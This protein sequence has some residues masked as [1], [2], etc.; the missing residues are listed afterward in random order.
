MLSW[1]GWLGKEIR[2]MCPP[3]T[4]THPVLTGTNRARRTATSL[5]RSTMLPLRHVAT[6]ERFATE[7]SWFTPTPLRWTLVRYSQGPRSLTDP[8]PNPTN[9]YF[10][11][12]LL[13]LALG[14]SK[15]H[16]KPVNPNPTGL[17]VADPQWN[18]E[19]L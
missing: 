16:S 18:S 6:V 7:Q 8:N 17:T 11:Y 5:M 12:S 19:S 13:I 10:T 1:H 2:M 14:H 3:K 4:V 15:G 9:R